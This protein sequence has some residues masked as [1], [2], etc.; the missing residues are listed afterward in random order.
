MV[1]LFRMQPVDF[2][3]C[4]SLRAHRRP[5]KPAL[6]WFKGKSQEARGDE[7]R[8][9]TIGIMKMTT[10]DVCD[11]LAT[12]G[13]KFETYI[14]KF[15]EEM[16]D[17]PLLRNLT[18][19]DLQQLGVTPGIHCTKIL[20]HR[21]I[22]VEKSFNKTP[23]QQ[24][25]LDILA[26]KTDI[27]KPKDEPEHVADRVF[28]SMQRA[29]MYLGT[30]DATFI[31]G[32]DSLLCEL[33]EEGTF[34]DALEAINHF[35]WSQTACVDQAGSVRDDV[36]ADLDQIVH[37]KH[38]FCQRIVTMQES[39][40]LLAMAMD[41]YKQKMRKGKLTESEK[42]QAGLKM[43]ESVQTW[44]GNMQELAEKANF[45]NRVLFQRA[46]GRL[47]MHLPGS[48]AVAANIEKLSKLTEEKEKE[49]QKCKQIR[50]LADRN[51]QLALEARKEGGLQGRILHAEEELN[52]VKG[53][54]SVLEEQ[55]QKYQ[56]LKED[57]R[58]FAAQQ[59]N[60]TKNIRDW[61]IKRWWRS[62]WK[63]EMS[64]YE[65]QTK[66]DEASREKD[67]Q[68]LDQDL[69]DIKNKLD[70]L[71]DQKAKLNDDIAELREKNSEEFWKNTLEAEGLLSAES[72]VE[73]I[74]K[75]LQDLQAQF[76]Q[77][78]RETGVA[79]P[80]LAAQ[81]IMQHEIS[82]VLLKEA[83][84]RSTEVATRMN[85]WATQVQQVI[86]DDHDSQIAQ[87]LL[88][89]NEEHQKQ[90]RALKKMKFPLASKLIGQFQI[91]DLIASPALNR[92]G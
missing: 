92:T 18:A 58:T 49:A 20:V 76:R 51:V 81:L 82:K 52:R 70:D 86:L 37:G 5:L 24:W 65:N 72:K 74:A 32:L 29:G 57:Y 85:N 89:V 91:P 34:F 17:G 60:E 3:G 41:T 53:Q 33:E 78:M 62:M 39:T 88:I 9:Q 54:Q 36:Q 19:D 2:V 90:Y 42:N 55:R 10:R 84:Q 80:D 28:L 67:I 25:P 77:A 61:H 56:K 7:G 69:K 13:S 47:R 50:N 48:K 8:D 64:I 38:A 73:E 31:R 4:R 12:L 22:L 45:S 68:V 43:E 40:K 15:Q 23:G 44:L 14:P 21:D 1:V 11:W 71:A 79:D 6:I 75:R 46:S 27:A 59:R 87:G 30:N 83:T 16:V 26:E 66:R 35:V 63:D